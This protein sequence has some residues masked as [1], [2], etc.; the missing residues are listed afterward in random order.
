MTGSWYGIRLE[1]L[2]PTTLFIAGNISKTTKLAVT[3]VADS[4]EAERPHNAFI[5]VSDRNIHV[6]HSDSATGDVE[7]TTDDLP[8]FE[9]QHVIFQ[10][11]EGEKLSFILADSETDGNIYIT[12]TVI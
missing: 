2:E 10:L 1:F 5:V 12:P 11:L 8:I 3:S 7:A 4:F 6:A 9:N